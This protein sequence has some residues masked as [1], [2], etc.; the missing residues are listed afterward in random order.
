MHE[1]GGSLIPQFTVMCIYCIV[2]NKLYTC[3]LTA[4][5][6]ITVITAILHLNDS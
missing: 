6:Q 3:I 1:T 5:D 2:H 4:D